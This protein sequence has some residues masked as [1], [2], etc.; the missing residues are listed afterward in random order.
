MAHAVAS[1]RACGTSLSARARAVASSCAPRPTAPPLTLC[2]FWTCPRGSSQGWLHA[3][4]P[5]GRRLH[6]LAS[7]FHGA[8]AE[9]GGGV[10]PG[11]LRIKR[12]DHQQW[13]RGCVQPSLPSALCCLPSGPPLWTPPPLAL[14]STLLSFPASLPA[15]L[16]P[17]ASPTDLDGDGDLDFLGSSGTSSLDGGTDFKD[18]VFINSGAST[19]GATHFTA[20]DVTSMLAT[21]RAKLPPPCITLHLNL[22]LL[23]P[24]ISPSMPTLSHAIPPCARPNARLQRLAATHTPCSRPILHSITL[25]AHPSSHTPCSTPC[26]RPCARPQRRWHGAYPACLPRGS[27]RR[28]PPRAPRALQDRRVSCIMSISHGSPTLLPSPAL[29][30]PALP[31]L[32]LPSLLHPHTAAAPAAVTSAATSTPSTRS[33]VRAAPPSPPPPMKAR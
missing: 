27:G 26:S 28:R 33:N 17:L 20:T 25:H 15:S 5:H 1:A 6:R 29:P 3:S 2:A 7:R 9:E 31:S 24:S 4:S 12:R 30:S 13:P 8:R 21:R 22:G 11:R 19:I 32:A 18:Y 14:L 23:S 16:P 10:A